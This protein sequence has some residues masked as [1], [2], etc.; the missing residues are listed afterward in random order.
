MLCAEAAGHLADEA[1]C[2]AG[3]GGG[4]VAV[5]VRVGGEVVE[6]GGGLAGVLGVVA[7]DEFPAVAT[8]GGEVVAAVVAVGEVHKEIGAVASVGLRLHHATEAAAVEGVAARQ[9]HLGCVE[10]GGVDV[11][12]GGE[13]RLH[14]ALADGHGLLGGD[15][16]V[17][18][19]PT[20]DAGHAHAAFVG[21]AFLAAIGGAGAVVL[22][23]AE[24]CVAAVVAHEDDEGVAVDAELL[25]LTEDGAEGVVHALDEGGVGLG[26]GVGTA[27]AVAA[28]VLRVG[29]EGVVHRVVGEGE[30]EGLAVSDGALYLAAGLGGKGVGEEGVGAVVAV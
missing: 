4:E 17:G 18:L 2:L 21:G 8:I 28:D 16:G 6:L 12:D 11:H 20:N 5:L 23:A 19:R 26:L 30:E 22:T 24:G 7:I 9:W 29:L 27:A 13:L 3:H 25:Q 1:A 15:A 10:H 14:G